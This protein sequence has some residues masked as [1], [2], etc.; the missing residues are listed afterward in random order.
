[1]SIPT[2]HEFDFDPT[3]GYGLSEL[4]ALRPPMAPTGF[5]AFWR[6]RYLA[7]REV[8]PNPRLSA[9]SQ[10]NPNWHVESITYTST[11]GVRICGWLL[12]P[13]HG[14][15]TRGLVVG[16]G[17]GGR[18]GPEFDI[19]VDDT[20]I[21]FPCSRGLSRSACPPIPAEA[22]G[23][24]L[25]KIGDPTRYILGGCVDDLWLAVSALTKLH[26]GIEGHIG[27]IGTSFGGGIGALAIPHDP[28]ITRGHL[29]VPTFGNMPLWLTLPTVGSGNSVQR[30]LKTHGQ[31]RASL[32]FFDAAIAATR[33]SVPM[34]VAVARFDPAVAPPCQFTVANA[35]NPPDH[36][37]TFV[38]D[39][40]HYDYPGMKEQHVLLGDRV[41]SFLEEL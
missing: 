21:L 24:V 29:I 7:A 5:D 13:K 2:E 32:A 40:G 16:H 12:R 19:P 17:Y 41:R 39:A 27:Y 18:G 28:R 9:S 26:P 33:I 34:L 37:E 38:L 36:H 31:A 1:M 10:S 4:L 23:H 3:Y 25:H 30:F 22:A 20:A 11:G 15:I 14:R 35:L 6:E 8:D